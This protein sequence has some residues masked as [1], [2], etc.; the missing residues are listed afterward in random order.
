MSP[1]AFERFDDMTLKRFS[2]LLLVATLF[3]VTSFAPL[4][5]RALAQ[6][7]TQGAGQTAVAVNA[8]DL[9]ARLAAIE[10]AIEEKR[11]QY[12]IPGVSLAIVLND[13]VIY[14]K[15][16]GLKDVE[17]NLPATPDTLFAIGSSTK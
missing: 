4:Q 9:N 11:R 13:K 12:H 5:R 6:S 7:T 17:R 10:Q 1:F 3:I 15:G 14:L 2:H 16:L 8:P